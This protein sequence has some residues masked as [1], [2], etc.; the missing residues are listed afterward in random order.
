M[1]QIKR[2]GVIMGHPNTQYIYFFLFVETV[3]KV[4]ADVWIYG[5]VLKLPWRIL[6]TDVKLVSV[7]P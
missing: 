1:F 6:H 3:N 5:T 4:D 7:P 2:K